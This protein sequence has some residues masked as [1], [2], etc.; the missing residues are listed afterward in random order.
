MT[1]CKS[2]DSQMKM[3]CPNPSWIYNPNPV[4]DKLGESKLKKW[5]VW[6]Q[7]GWLLNLLNVN[8]V[9]PDFLMPKPDLNL[10]PDLFWDKSGDFQIKEMKCP[11]PSRVTSK[12][13]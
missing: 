7:V 13:M 6:A 5:N 4:W 11:S 12:L 8:R 9:T 1:Q 3:E 10:W 2:G